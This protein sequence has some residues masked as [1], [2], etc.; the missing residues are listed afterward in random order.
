MKLDEIE[1]RTN[2]ATPGP[3]IW[4]PAYEGAPMIHIEGNA[5]F[6]VGVAQG[7]RNENSAAEAQEAADATFIAAA[8]TDVPALVARVREL[9]TVI[10]ELEKLIHGRPEV[11]V[12]ARYGDG[13]S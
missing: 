2:A 11:L 5:H 8:R 9:E 6:G 7:D 3:W 10:R 12:A 13:E 1:A 4:E